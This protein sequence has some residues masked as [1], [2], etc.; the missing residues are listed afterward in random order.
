MKSI[1]LKLFSGIVLIF[2]IFILG[3]ATYG[4]TYK[5]FFQREKLMEMN[6]VIEE[7]KNYIDKD[8]N[9]RVDG[10]L[11]GLSEKYS[12]QIDIKDVLTSESI[13]S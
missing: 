1:K 2:S 11:E 4:V 6:E 3:I 7:I 8:Y 5:D 10:K 12:V 13:F 9:N